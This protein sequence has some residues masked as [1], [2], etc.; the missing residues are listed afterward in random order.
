MPSALLETAVACSIRYQ[1]PQ[2][3]DVTNI[4]I[5]KEIENNKIL[6]G[7][8]LSESFLLVTAINTQQHWTEQ[9]Q[10]SPALLLGGERGGGRV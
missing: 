2:P 5:E 6:A 4:K 9:Q 8:Q 1:V 10:L 7:T 3:L